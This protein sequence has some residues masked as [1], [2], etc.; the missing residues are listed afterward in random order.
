MK[1]SLIFYVRIIQKECINTTNF[2]VTLIHFYFNTK[3]STIYPY[4]NKKYYICKK[5]IFHGRINSKRDN[6]P[7]GYICS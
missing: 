7:K 5:I 3:T 2:K 6:K 1:C 4:C